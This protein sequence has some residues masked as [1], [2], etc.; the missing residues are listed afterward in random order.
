[1][2]IEPGSIIT[3]NDHNTLDGN[4]FFIVREIEY[5]INKTSNAKVALVCSA[6]IITDFPENIVLQRYGI[7]D[8]DTLTVNEKPTG[9]I[10]L[11]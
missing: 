4:Q 10:L 9:D 11:E 8:P 2:T 1:M 5:D 7:L 3:V 6:T